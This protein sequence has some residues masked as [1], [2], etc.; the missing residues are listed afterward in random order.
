M[1]TMPIGKWLIVII[2]IC[3]KL[4]MKLI[5]IRLIEMFQLKGN[6]NGIV[7]NELI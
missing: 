7:I 6:T 2:R 5:V 3:F 4:V 1:L